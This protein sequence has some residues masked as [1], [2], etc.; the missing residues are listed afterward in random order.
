MGSVQDGR[1]AAL[2]LFYNGK[3]ISTDLKKYLMNFSYNDS[4]PGEFDDISITLDDRDRNWIKGWA[5]VIGDTIKA[6]IHTE[7]WDKQ[8]EKKKLPCGTFYLD[9]ADMEGPPDNVTMQATSLPIEG[10]SVKQEKRS[11]AW[12][13]VT[14]KTLSTEV[15]KAAKL[16]LLYSASANPKFDRLD[17]SDQS[18][19]SFLVETAIKEGIAVKASGSTL[20][21]F[22]EE[23][24]EKKD[25]VINIERGKA[26]VISYSFSINSE[27]SAYGSCEVTYTVAKTKKTSSK[28]IKGSYK[29]PGLKGLPVL[30]LNEQVETVA[31]ANRLAKNRLREQNKKA[32]LASFVMDGDIRL[33][34]SVT[35]N[36]NGWGKFDGKYIIVSASHTLG[37]S[38]YQTPI[39]VRKVLGWS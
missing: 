13:K 39:N 5:P 31:E 26:N 3:N 18:D 15:A 32:G 8:G 21:L 25:A 2:V 33:A 11:K 37:G 29:I 24:Y 14:L 7:H 16:K 1:R 22:D 30:R 27:G 10:A 19:I 20:V 12:E 23:V 9:S 36:V 38:A 4:A 6:E 34:S 17:Q 35:V 28:V